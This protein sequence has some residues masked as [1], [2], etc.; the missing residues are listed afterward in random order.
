MTPGTLTKCYIDLGTGD[1]NCIQIR[2][3]HLGSHGPQNT[4]VPLSDGTFY[5]LE[6]VVSHDGT[7]SKNRHKDLPADQLPN[8]GA[9]ATVVKSAAAHN[10]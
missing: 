2:K 7:E 6:D 3:Q 5:S 8:G 4:S 9:T 1:E 10:K